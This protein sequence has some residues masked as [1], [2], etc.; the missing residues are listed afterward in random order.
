MNNP[1][2][3]ANLNEKGP[4]HCDVQMRNHNASGSYSSGVSLHAVHPDPSFT[5]N[6]HLSDRLDRSIQASDTSRPR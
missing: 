6:V 2:I 3:Y 1:Y 4:I 5:T